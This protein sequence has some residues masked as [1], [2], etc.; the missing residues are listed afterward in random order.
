MV[1]CSIT[2]KLNSTS[3]MIGKVTADKMIAKVIGKD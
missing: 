3:G 2:S 1:M